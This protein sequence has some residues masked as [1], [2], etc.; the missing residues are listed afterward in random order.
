M[1]SYKTLIIAF[2]IALVTIAAVSSFAANKGKRNKPTGVPAASQLPSAAYPA[3][4]DNQGLDRANAELN[5]NEPNQ[6]QQG[7]DQNDADARAF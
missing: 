6:F 2:A 7:L 3:I 1:I 5:K 4:I